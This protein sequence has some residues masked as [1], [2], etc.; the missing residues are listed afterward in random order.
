MKRFLFVSLIAVATLVVSAGI[1]GCGE[2]KNLPTKSTSTSTPPVD[3][4]LGAW[5]T[6]VWPFGPN[7]NPSDWRGVEGDR[8]GGGT[9]SACGGTINSHSGADYYARDLSRKTGETSGRSI[10]AGFSGYVVKAGSAGGYGLCVV[11]YDPSRRLAIRYAHLSEVGVSEGMCIA[12][13]AYIGRVGNTPGG[14]SPHLHL[15]VY[16]NIN[17]FINGDPSRPVIPTVCDSDYYACR[18]FFMS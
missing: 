10:Y 12:A 1:Q 16:E 3:L 5:T 8:T 2:E 15:V 11:I 6:I 14:F 17:H 4:S 13:R 18:V 9:I 7:E